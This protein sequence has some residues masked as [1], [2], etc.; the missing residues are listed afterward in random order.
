MKRRVVITGIGIKSPIGNSLIEFQENLF[1]MRSGIKSMD[2][3][4]TVIGLK[5]KVAGIVPFIDEKIIPRQ[6]R[7]SM[8]RGS[9]LAAIASKDAISD[10]ALSQEELS[11]FRTGLIYGSTVGGSATLERVFGDLRVDNS[12]MKQTSMDFLKYMSNTVCANL[13][14]F[15]NIKGMCL[16]ICSA[17]TSSS[18]AI[19]LGYEL[20]KNGQLD[21]AICGGSEG[22]H[23]AMASIFDVVGAASSTYNET[24]EKSSRPFDKN[25]DG[26]VVAEGAGTLILEDMESALNRGAKVYGEIIS[27]S[28]N[29]NGGHMT[30][31][32]Q[33][34]IIQ[35][36]QSAI[37]I[38]DLKITDIDYLNAHATSTHLGDIVESNAIHAIFQDKVPVS[39]IKGQIGHTL[40]ACG[41]IES[42]A[43]ISSLLLNKLPSNLNIDSLDEEC[44]PLDYIKKVRE[45]EVN[46]ALTN[47]F[48][49]GGINTSLIFKKY[50]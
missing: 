25:R 18:Q 31:P 5:T 8:D 49:F 13:A 21:R 48:A 14:S 33:D 11:S 42:I 10:S 45:Q 28:T 43:T 12:Y 47:N 32:D 29:C 6:N 24:P 40:G 39:S 26:V 16:P 20:I 38:A 4:D 36:M 34:S 35:V 19:G 22:M 7:R 2:C 23:H 27:Y 30:N 41:V 1:N 50:K 37:D 46:I 9:I 15:F 44:S 17:C 3:W